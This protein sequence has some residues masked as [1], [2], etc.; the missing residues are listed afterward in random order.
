MTRP[1]QGD[2]A[3][4][5]TPLNNWLD[6]IVG[7][8]VKDFGALGNGVHDDAS[9]INAAI[10]ALPATGGII[11]FPAGDYAVGSS[12]MIGDGSAAGIST[13]QGV[14]L[15]GPAA[16]TGF[17]SGFTAY[18]AARLKWIGGSSTNGIV[19]INGPLF[20]W[21][22]KNLILDGNG[23][24]VRGLNVISAMFGNV[25][26]LSVTG[27]LNQNSIR[28]NTLSAS[29]ALAA[30]NTNCMHN[31][32][33]NIFI[34][35]PNVTSGAINVISISGVDITSNTCFDVWDNVF[36]IIGQTAAATEVA[37]IRFGASDNVHFNNVHFYF[38]P[39][40]SGI[41][42]PVLF[43]YST[44]DNWPADDSVMW[45]DF[46]AQP[47]YTRVAANNGAPGSAATP[48]RILGISATNSGGYPADPNLAN[49]SWGFTESNP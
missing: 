29:G 5:G 35:V 32:W 48:N 9:N 24:S 33:R 44:V 22:L 18:G 13:R 12:I 26:N 36:I 16:P 27:C 46:G 10:A 28:T 45:V 17:A 4:W 11:Y 19:Q 6:E 34:K 31:Y 49:L 25:E 3:P 15:V 37:G 8:N 43:D 14:Y 23:V 47:G 21:G 1:V 2:P 30:Y 39:T 20:G 40:Q 7:L 38:N 42:E 41:A